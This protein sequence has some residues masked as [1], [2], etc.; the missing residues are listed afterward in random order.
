[1]PAD[2]GPFVGERVLQRVADPGLGREVN[3][4]PRPALAHQAFEGVGLGDVHAH[5]LEIRPLLERPD[6]GLLERRI[7]IGVEVVDADDLLAAVQQP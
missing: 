5:Q 2:I 7:V 6:P 4:A 3:D 1:M